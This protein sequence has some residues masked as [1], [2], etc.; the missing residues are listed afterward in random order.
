MTTFFTADTHFG[1]ARIIDYCSR[2]FVDV[3]E[4]DEALITRWNERVGDDDTVYHLGDFTLKSRGFARRMF[5]RLRGHIK[6]LGL[7]WHHDKG[8]VPKQAGPSDFGSASGHPVEILPPLLAL[9]FSGVPCGVLTLSHY[10]MAQW[11]AAYHGAWQLHGHSHGAHRGTGAL[12]D[13]GVD[14]HDYAPVALEALEAL[15]PK[16]GP[17]AVGRRAHL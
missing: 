17:S 13:V 16:P 9:R 14:V 11:E 15:I 4:M 7:P 12:L 5:G 2:P 8:W 1:H 6:V 10:P 3:D